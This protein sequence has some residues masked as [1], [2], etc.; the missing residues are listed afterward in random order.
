MGYFESKGGGGKATK[1]DAAALESN[2]QPRTRPSFG[3]KEPQEGAGSWGEL[4]LPPRE[5]ASPQKRRE[6]GEGI[7]Q[8]HSPPALQ[9]PDIASHWPDPTGHPRAREPDTGVGQTRAS[10]HSWRR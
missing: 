5:T 1:D 2:Q 3:L 6:Q 4:W 9:A 10:H 7:S 8:C